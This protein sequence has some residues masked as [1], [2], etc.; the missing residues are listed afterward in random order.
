MDSFKF[1]KK[2]CVSPTLP[3]GSLG[4][5][6]MKP[7]NLHCTHDRW[8]FPLL[9][10]QTSCRNML[11]GTLDTTANWEGKDAHSTR[12]QL[13]TRFTPWIPNA[14]QGWCI[15][16][17]RTWPEKLHSTITHHE[18]TTRCYNL[19]S[20]NCSEQTARTNPCSWYLVFKRASTPIRI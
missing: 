15:K 12:W 14:W 20:S 18:A 7:K 5:T 3:K 2:H 17:P 11:K 1:N 6:S 13:L 4:L 8:V 19:F 16:W 9:T 10:L